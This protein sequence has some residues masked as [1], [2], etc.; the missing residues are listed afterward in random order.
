MP[1][2]TS[3]NPSLEAERVLPVADAS[4]DGGVSRGVP[5]APSTPPLGVVVAVGVGRHLGRRRGLG[6]DDRASGLLRGLLG[7][8]LRGLLGRLLR[9]GLGRRGGRRRGRRGA[10]TD[11]AEIE[12][13][14]ALD[15]RRRVEE[16]VST[17]DHVPVQDPARVLVRLD[18]ERAHGLER[19]GQRSRR[20]I[21]LGLHEVPQHLTGLEVDVVAVVAI[22]A[23]VPADRR[24]LVEVVRQRRTRREQR[25]GEDGEQGS[26]PGKACG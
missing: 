23:G 15:A 16:H 12:V 1:A 11:V 19:H 9:R 3:R 21:G 7:R 4:V 17:R 2:S 13:A 25:E 10:D 26:Q 5:V 20:R 18:G 14:V 24:R 6:R 22:A 8:L